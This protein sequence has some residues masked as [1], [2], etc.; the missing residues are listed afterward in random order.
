MAARC[1]ATGEVSDKVTELLKAAE[2]AVLPPR[3]AIEAGQ[4]ADLGER[5]LSTLARR[6]NKRTRLP[7]LRCA[8]SA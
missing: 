4:L 5:A 7:P 3:S 6:P 1:G 8:A 2:A